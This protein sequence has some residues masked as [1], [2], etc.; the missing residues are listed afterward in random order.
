MVILSSDFVRLSISFTTFEA[1]LWLEEIVLRKD[2]FDLVCFFICVVILDLMSSK[3]VTSP[4]IFFSVFCLLFISEINSWTWSFNERNLASAFCFSSGVSANSISCSVLSIASFSVFTLSSA[5][6]TNLSILSTWAFFLVRFS[7]TS[8]TS[9]FS[10]SIFLI[11]FCKP[12]AERF[13][14]D[15]S[16]L[17]SSSAFNFSLV[18]SFFFWRNSITIFSNDANEFLKIKSG[19]SC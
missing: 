17:S 6:A 10:D 19:L 1:F 18:A 13:S 8:E 4:V 12:V 7:E 11:I 5:F 14:A 15:W 2:G 9:S 16:C 3:L